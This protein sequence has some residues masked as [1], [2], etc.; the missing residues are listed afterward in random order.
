MPKLKGW[1][2]MIDCTS[3]FEIRIHIRGGINFHSC[4]ENVCGFFCKFIGK[5]TYE[6]TRMQTI[7]ARVIKELSE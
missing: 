7:S 5:S 4:L 6:I 1:H 2:A 3:I